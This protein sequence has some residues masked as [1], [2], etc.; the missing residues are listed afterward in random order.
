MKREK[1]LYAEKYRKGA[2]KINKDMLPTC[3]HMGFAA[4]IKPDEAIIN[5]MGIIER[6]GEKFIYQDI[7]VYFK[8]TE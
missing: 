8:R 3:R 4:Q 6:D 1:T 7:R 5:E 2:N